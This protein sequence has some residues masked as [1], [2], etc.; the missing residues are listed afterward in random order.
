MKLQSDHYNSTQPE[1]KQPRNTDV[2][3]RSFQ[4]RDS[5]VVRNIFAESMGE[6][7]GPLVRDVMFQAVLYGLCLSLPA[8]VLNFVWSPWFLALYF[9]V[10]FALLLALFA[11]LQIGFSRYIQN[12]LRTDLDNVESI[13][14]CQKRS[15][16]WVAELNGN[17]IGM[18]ALV[19]EYNHENSFGKPREAVGRL[20][21]MAVLP[22]FR[23][24]GVAKKLLNELLNYA[25]EIGYKE[26]VLLTTSA[27]EAAL[28]FYPKHGFQLVSKRLAN[29]ALRGFYHYVYC[30]DLERLN[31]VI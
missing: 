18:V 1:V 8:S 19:P 27:Q 17:I 25:R 29:I 24:L 20:R 26:V 14:L 31:K 12:C 10:L 28:R 6:M 23:R 3:I 13:Y 5:H 22:E 9:F 11:G 30:Y 2:I 21:R 16:M 7:R 4:S 15:H